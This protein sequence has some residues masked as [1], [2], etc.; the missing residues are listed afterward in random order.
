M[1]D[2]TLILIKDNKVHKILPL[3]F[4]TKFEVIRDAPILK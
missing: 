1:T 4:T 3:D 2:K